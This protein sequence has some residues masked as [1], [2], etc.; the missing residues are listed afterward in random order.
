MPIRL[1]GELP[2]PW[3]LV[4]SMLPDFML[5]RMPRIEMEAASITVPP[6]GTFGENGELCDFFRSQGSRLG[7]LFLGEARE[8][9]DFGDGGLDHRALVFQPGELEGRFRS[10]RGTLQIDAAVDGAQ[11]LV[12]RV[13]V[14][15]GRASGD[16]LE[17]ANLQFA[18]VLAGGVVKPLSL[19]EVN[20]KSRLTGF[21]GRVKASTISLGACLR[22][23]SLSRFAQRRTWPR[24]VRA[25]AASNLKVRRGADLAHV[26]FES[27]ELNRITASIWSGRDVQKIV[28]VAVFTSAKSVRGIAF[29]AVR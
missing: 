23:S 22:T 7:P 9:R 8:L 28:D 15:L 20:L 18:N 6:C 5:P 12:K 16:E 10:G 13:R 24:S 27:G 4:K 21:L 2:C 14:S 19:S 26:D 1:V 17:V 25:W 3:T 29:S 11:R